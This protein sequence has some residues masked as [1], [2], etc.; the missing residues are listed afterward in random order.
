MP[1]SDEELAAKRAQVEKL[2]VNVATE[3]AKRE[4]RER[5]LANDVH[6]A[7]LDAEIA[8]LEVQLEQA[9]ASNKVAAVKEGATGPLQ[10]A[11]ED[12]KAAEAQAK[13]V[14]ATDKES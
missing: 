10:A 7:Q 4:Q 12:K 14:T 2:R 13:A 8:Q 1:T 3:N 5:E 11:V 6:A 9:K